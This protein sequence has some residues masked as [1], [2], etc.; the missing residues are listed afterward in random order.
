VNFGRI[1]ESTRFEIWNKGM[2]LVGLSKKKQQK[3]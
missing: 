1:I 2:E 3:T